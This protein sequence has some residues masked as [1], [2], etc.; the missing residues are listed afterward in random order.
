MY[1]GLYELLYHETHLHKQTTSHIHL[2]TRFSPLALLLLC[3]LKFII[4]RVSK[5]HNRLQT[6]YL[7]YKI[8]ISD[9]VDESN[10]KKLY[11]LST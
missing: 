6:G 11:P 3:G 7:I 4:Q 5:L 2:L 9:G 1:N 8:N 10:K